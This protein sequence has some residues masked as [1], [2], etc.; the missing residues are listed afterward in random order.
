MENLAFGNLKIEVIVVALPES[1]IRLLW[2]GKSN[3]RTPGRTLDPFL[4]GVV[5]EA[6]QQNARVEAHFERLEHFNSSTITS[7]IGLVQKAQRKG[8]RLL[9]LFDRTVKWQKLS[10][11]ALRV[12]VKGDGLLEIRS[13]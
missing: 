10:F 9:I 2:T 4:S 7:I 5:E 8:V 13:T 12:L 3:D 1:T 11:D 6:A